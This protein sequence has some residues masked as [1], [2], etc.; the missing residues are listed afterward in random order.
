MMKERRKRSG[1]VM[2]FPYNS[3]WL[4]CFIERGE[5]KAGNQTHISGGGTARNAPTDRHH[6]NTEPATLFNTNNLREQ[7]N[8]VAK[9]WCE[10]RAGQRIKH[11]FYF[12]PCVRV[13]RERERN[14]YIY[15]WAGSVCTTPGG[16][17]VSSRGRWQVHRM[18]VGAASAACTWR[19]R[20]LIAPSITSQ[21]PAHKHT[22]H[23]AAFLP[24]SYMYSGSS[25]PRALSHTF[26][27]RLIRA[28]PSRKTH[29][30]NLYICI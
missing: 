16:S 21:L 30:A 9:S 4:N 3:A 1:L 12:W 13:R 29:F 27:S 18:D 15:G 5:Q 19:G 20:G 24:F 7:R 6:A 28:E 10:R 26:H 23:N 25:A 11:K 2:E 17:H 14:A 22:T 8:N